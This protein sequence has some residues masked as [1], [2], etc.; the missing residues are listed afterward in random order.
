MTASITRSV[1][2]FWTKPSRSS[3]RASW[4]SEKHHLLSWVL[5]TETTRRHYP[6]TTLLTDDQGADLLINGIGLE[7]DDVS[8]ELNDLNQHDPEWWALGKLYAYRA[9]K[10]PF[11]HIDADVFLWKALP[12]EVGS[13][14]LFAQNPEFISEGFWYNPQEFIEFIEHRKG[15]V[16]RELTW[17][18]L[19]ESG[20]RGD[21]CGIFGGNQ[22]DFIQYYADTVISLIENESNFDNWLHLPGKPIHMMLIEQYMLSACI[23]YQ[24]NTPGSYYQDI[25]IEY[26]FDSVAKAYEPQRAKAIGYTHL[27]GDAKRNPEIATRLERKVARD[28]PYQYRKCLRH[29]NRTNIFLAPESVRK[30]DSPQAQEDKITSEKVPKQEQAKPF[31]GTKQFRYSSKFLG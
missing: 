8:T 11:V 15:W 16:P 17:F 6:E 4:F 26:L 25:Q 27:I 10:K 9:Q 21:C 18:S 5:S 24:R 29:L 12:S 14:P 31:R 3:K 20:Q 13:A 7:F 23:E 22:V 1:W 19:Q 30:F 2:S 28:Y